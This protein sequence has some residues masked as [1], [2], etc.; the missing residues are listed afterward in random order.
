MLFQEG[1]ASA[2]ALASV[3]DIGQMNRV[4]GRQDAG[5]CRQVLGIPQCVR[6]RIQGPGR[7]WRIAG[8]S[9]LESGQEVRN[10]VEVA[11]KSFPGWPVGSRSFC[12]NAAM[13]NAQV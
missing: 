9:L 13:A 2:K 10:W 4:A 6:D 12:S 1:V 8:K 3:A 7:Y 11:L 5:R